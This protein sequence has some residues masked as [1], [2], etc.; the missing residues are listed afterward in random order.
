MKQNVI[1]TLFAFCITTSIEAKKAFIE[2]I[3]Y[4]LHF[5]TKTASVI[6]SDSYSGDITIPASVEDEGFTYSVT[7]IENEAFKGCSS[8]RRVTLPYSITSIKDNAFFGCSSMTYIAFPD[9]MYTIGDKAFS[10]CTGLTGIIIPESVSSIGSNAFEKCKLEWI[11]CMNSTPPT[12]GSDVFNMNSILLY[13]PQGALERYSTQWQFPVSSIREMG[14]SPEASTLEDYTQEDCLVAEAMLKDVYRSTITGQ[15]CMLGG[16]E[17][18]LPNSHAY[19]YQYICTDGYAQYAVAPHYYFPYTINHNFYSTYYINASFNPGPSGRFLGMKNAIVPAINAEK[20]GVFPEMKAIHT[21]MYDYAAIE[22]ADVYGALP[23]SDYK[24]GI[25]DSSKTTY[26]DLSTIYSLVVSDIDDIIHT[27]HYF[28]HQPKWYQ[29]KVQKMLYR[30]EK[31]VQ[32][33]YTNR[34]GFDTW[35]R[36]ANSLKL[37]MAMR[38]VKVKP[39]LAKQWAEEAVAGGVIESYE[40]QVGLTPMNEGFSHP[41]VYITKS[42]NESRLCASFESLLMSLDHPYTKYMFNKNYEKLVNNITGEITPANTRIVGL[43]AGAYFE[44]DQS[45]DENQYVGVSQVNSNMIEKAPL[46]LIKW[47]EVDFLRAEGALR[48]WE[49]GGDAQFFYER[50]IKNASLVDPLLIDSDYNNL[51]EAYMQKE[52]ATDYTYVDPFGDTPDMPSVTKIGVK[53]NE[54]DDRETKLEKI[55]TQKYIALYPNSYEAWAELRRTGYP[56]LFPVLNP[57]DGDGSLKDGDMIRRMPFPGREDDSTN[58]IIERSGI[59]ALGGP[60]L[61]AT[62]LWWDVDS[63]NFPTGITTTQRAG[64][65]SAYYSL[66]GRRIAQPQRG[67]NIV[68]HP[69]GTS[70]KVLVK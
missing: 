4:D 41:L 6:H 30:Y 15:Y 16:K 59:P 37:R 13:V 54:G 25:E 45:F 34:E 38:I 50:G 12:L 8:L 39:E 28:E 43:R 62:R 24:K 46:W 7:C 22:C 1:L 32:D 2:R 53:W 29:E 52:T 61:Q 10:G 57:Q 31:I 14:T 58:D 49:M 65:T 11:F 56:K 63:T 18:Q 66:D 5:S 70:Q 26:E 3:Y 68:C 51:V 47:A 27:L 35:I 60:D 64:T 21:L 17:G 23:Y 40:Q 20:A 42:W 33:A 36:F 67:V 48:G 9:N 44:A 69:D 19:Q 55:I